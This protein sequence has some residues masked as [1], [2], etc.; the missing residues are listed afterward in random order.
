MSTLPPLHG[1]YR[2]R[3]TT[4]RSPVTPP[5]VAPTGRGATADPLGIVTPNLK[6]TC[7]AAKFGRPHVWLFGFWHGEFVIA[8]GYVKCGSCGQIEAD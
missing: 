2:P 4:T 8:E 5:P 1:G 7:P 3:A 6:K